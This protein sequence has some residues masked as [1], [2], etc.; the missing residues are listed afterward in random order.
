MLTGRASVFIDSFNM[1]SK[2]EHIRKH[3]T[4]MWAKLTR[5]SF[6]VM[7]SITAFFMTSFSLKYFSMYFFTCSSENPV[8]ST[9]R[10]KGILPFTWS[11]SSGLDVIMTTE[12]FKI[13]PLISLAHSAATGIF[14]LALFG[15]RSS[16]SLTMKFCFEYSSKPSRIIKT[17]SEWSTM[18]SNKESS[19]FECSSNT[20]DRLRISLKVTSSS[21]SK[22]S[23]R[24]VSKYANLKS[25]TFRLLCGWNNLLSAQ[26]RIKFW[27]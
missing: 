1:Y 17:F 7:W 16:K 10:S 15:Y 2:Y 22:L 13:F 20:E 8:I 23:W 27:Q 21:L 26:S 5:L 9:Y 12:S 25:G 24:K 11:Y 18:Y 19:I 14:S 3:R 6:F 4:G